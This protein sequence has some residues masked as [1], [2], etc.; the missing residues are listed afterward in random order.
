MILNVKSLNAIIHMVYFFVFYIF[1]V[2]KL[3]YM[4]VNPFVRIIYFKRIILLFAMHIQI[5]LKYFRHIMW[6]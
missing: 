1:L 5:D 2:Y 4:L 6:L 3:E